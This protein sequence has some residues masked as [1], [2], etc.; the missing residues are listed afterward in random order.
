MTE[1]RLAEEAEQRAGEMQRVAADARRDVARGPSR[2]LETL[3]SRLKTQ[4]AQKDKRLAQLKEAIKELER[5]LVEAMQKAAD[6]AMRGA[7]KTSEKTA[8][9]ASRGAEASVLAAKLKRA[10]DEL[11]KMKD[12]E[13]R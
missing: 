6:V 10:Q 1:A 11:A 4:L 9:R 8:A 13:A 12:R 2:V 5:K 3:V 7:E